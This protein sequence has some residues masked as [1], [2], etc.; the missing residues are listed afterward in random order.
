MALRFEYVSAESTAP[1]C[2]AAV[3]VHTC[4]RFSVTG[5]LG[6]RE[7]ACWDFKESICPL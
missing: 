5:V 3:F 2:S 6:L 1:P 4:P 7:R